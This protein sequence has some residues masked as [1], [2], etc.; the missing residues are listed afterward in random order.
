MAA[1]SANP[2]E[3][4]L[5]SFLR[6]S[7]ASRPP[8]TPVVESALDTQIQAYL[9]CHN[10]E[11][12]MRKKDKKHHHVQSSVTT[13]VAASTPPPAVPNKPS[14]E[15]VLKM[16]RGASPTVAA[17]VPTKS[18]TAPATTAATSSSPAQNQSGSIRRLDDAQKLNMYSSY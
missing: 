9:D 4:D 7:F 3:L 18:A 11:Y 6:T 10:E 12:H 13:P 2:R 16:M 14:L 1:K 15:D 5:N 8:Q 17:P